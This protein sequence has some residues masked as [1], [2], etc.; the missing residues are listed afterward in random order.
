[1]SITEKVRQY[2]IPCSI[3]G[4]MAHPAPLYALCI[5]KNVEA[6]PSHVPCTEYPQSVSQPSHWAAP[7]AYLIS[8]TCN[9]RAMIGQEMV[10]QK[11]L[12]QEI[13]WAGEWVALSLLFPKLYHSEFL[14]SY[15]IINFL[16]IIL[17]LLFYLKLASQRYFSACAHAR[18]N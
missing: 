5:L 10:K 9:H 2:N 6:S 14:T 17:H 11:Q 1:M 7:S 18:D 13:E 4:Q 8:T 3:W 15:V 12:M 16:P